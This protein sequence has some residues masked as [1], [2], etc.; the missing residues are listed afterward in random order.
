MIFESD[1]GNNLIQIKC[2]FTFLE[3]NKVKSE[4]LTEVRWQIEEIRSQTTDDRKKKIEVRNLIN[5]IL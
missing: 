3:K 4:K 1:I 5:I 2:F